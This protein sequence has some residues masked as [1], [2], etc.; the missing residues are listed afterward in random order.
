MNIKKLTKRVA[1]AGMIAA[2][3]LVGGY[4]IT[5]SHL[6]KK[7]EHQDE[8]DVVASGIEKIVQGDTSNFAASYSRFLSQSGYQRRLEQVKINNFDVLYVDEAGD[9]RVAYYR[10]T[11]TDKKTGEQHSNL[12]SF[13]LHREGSE[14]KIIGE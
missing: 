13:V 11:Y 2:A 9:E 12:G 1:L 10:V 3:A 7:Y 6:T 14:W 5:D 4:Y 8:R